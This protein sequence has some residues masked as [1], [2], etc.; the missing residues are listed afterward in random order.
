MKILKRIFSIVVVL[1]I[2]MVGLYRLAVLTERKDS[3]FKYKPF[4]QQKENFDVLF[5]G[6]SHVINGIFPMELWRDYG[7]V[8]YNFGGHANSLAIS[9][10]QMVNAF[11][12]TTPD[13][14]SVV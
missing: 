7:I 1:L 11:D 5:M 4:Y 10:W 2:V 8:S 6:S 13:R 14:K 12:Y 3:Q 9:Y